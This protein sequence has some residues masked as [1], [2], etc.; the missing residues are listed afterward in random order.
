MKKLNTSLLVLVLTSS[1]AV[2]NAQQKKDTMKTKEIE[3]V[4]VTAL[5]IK[6]EK[7]SLGYSTTEVKGDQLAN[8]PVANVTDALA[9]QVAGLNITQSGTMGGSANMI[10]R[11][12]KSLVG[13]NQ[14]LVVVDGTPINNETFNQVNI[15]S[16]KGAYDY[17]NG[18]ADINPNDIESVNV[19]KG[20]AASALYGSRGMNGV[21]MI[22][23]KKGKKSRKIG[24][25]FNHSTTLGFV[26]RSTLPKYQK[27]YGGGYTGTSF[28]PGNNDINGDGVPD[29]IIYT[30]DDASFGSRF[31]PNLMVY[32]WDSQYPQLPGYL[33]P[34]RFVAG[35]DPNVIWG[36]AA[37]YQNSVAFSSGNEKGKYRLGYT[38]FLQEGSLDNSKITKNTIDF[39]ADYNFTEKLSVFG[40]ISYINTMGKGRVLT[41]Y[42]SRNPMQS[43][44]QWWNMS[45]DMDKQKD[46]YNL[47]GQNMT[48]NIKDYQTQGI[49]YADNY[50]FNRYKNYQTDDRNRYFGNFGL[51]YK[52]TDW[53]G[54][55]VRYTFDTFDELREERVA[56]GSSGNQGRIRNGGKGEYYFLN[57]KVSEDNYDLM[58]NVNKNFGS[59][60]NLTGTIG[61]NL[62][63]N[64]RYGNSAVTNGG[65]KISGIYSITN[66]AQPLTE[67]NL[68]NFNIR[69]K[70]DGIYAQASLG[71]KNM[72]F[73][74]GSARTDRSSA[75]PVNN[76]RYWYY[77][78]SGSFIFSELLKDK[79]V[80]NFGKLRLNYAEVGND[81]GAY[82]LFNTYTLNAAFNGSY[83]AFNP[84]TTANND[85]KPERMRELE[86]GLEMSFF[87]N[88]LSFDVSVYKSK[89]RDLITDTDVSSGS[90]FTRAWM[91]SGDIENKG[92]EA[93]LTVVPIKTTNFKWEMTANWSKNK[94]T[95]TKINGD[96][97]YLQ[98]GSMWNVTTGG[99][100]GESTGT[101]RGYDYTY[102]NGQKVVGS[103]GKYLRGD[104]SNAIIGDAV[105]K[106]RGG[107]LNTITYKNLSLSFLIDM[108]QGGDVFSQDMAFG[109]SSGLYAETAG[110]NDLGNPK[111]NKLNNGGGIILPGVKA[112]G[113]PNDIRANFSDSNNPYGYTGGSGGKEAPEKLFVYDASFVKL[114]NVTISYKLPKETFGNSFIDSMTLSLIGRNLWIIHKNTPYTDP[115]SGMSAGNVMGFQNGAHPAFKEIGASVKVEF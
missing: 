59:D 113:T 77:S 74:D 87:K 4:V 36:T 12:T 19:L 21:I 82:Q 106:W 60:F 23:T 80:I 26:D 102:L 107:L 85:L 105:P 39:S 69:K 15:S 61:W 92:I 53:L 67:A 29:K 42:D 47:T 109:L 111:R 66:T 63:A 110:L 11:G 31:D 93:R 65:L 91:N 114:R 13:S 40:N 32:N 57:H 49:G 71:Y 96:N 18:M 52:I 7:R 41:G 30:Y 48:W 20:A 101:I 90:G 54:A 98:L 112:D 24:V 16:G 43:F 25:E 104:K 8:V 79:N 27:E 17:S 35:R 76:N 3:G 97:D 89:T 72:L 55:M 103:D 6:R 88:R 56:K 70:V 46:A 83:N 34:T 28:Y 38:N 10:I 51:N 86:A 94:N 73:I 44:R 99:Q 68:T 84:L 58:F 108:K 14:A 5:G 33:K 50:Y 100:L 64:N 95:V 22:T 62:R 1:I 115:E 37:T 75:L 2:T 9:G 45:V 81:T 78:A